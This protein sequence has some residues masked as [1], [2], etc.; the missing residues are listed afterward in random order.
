MALIP[1]LAEQILEEMD[2]ESLTNEL[3]SLSRTSRFYARHS[4]SQSGS[5]VGSASDAYSDAGSV[6]VSSYSGFDGD[7]SSINMEASTSSWVDRFSTSSSHRE[8]HDFLT[9]AGSQ[10]SDSIT[11]ASSSLSYN[12]V[13]SSHVSISNLERTNSNLH[14]KK[15]PLPTLSA[16]A[17]ENSTRTKSQLWKE[18]KML[19]M[20]SNSVSLASFT[21][22]ISALTRTLTTLYTTTLLSLLTSIQ[23][24]LLARERYLASVLSAER[25]ERIREAAPTLSGLI[26]REAVSRV[27]DI[28][29]LWPSWCADQEDWDE[30]I[31]GISDETEMRFLTLSW[32]ILHVGWK[33]VAARVRGSVEAA[34]EGYVFSFW[35]H[36]F[37][38]IFLSEYPSRRNCHL[39]NF[40]L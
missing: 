5:E 16:S 29:A 17:R 36:V 14:A 39:L 4:A 11:T 15:E 13:A 35:W 26:L 38:D 18:V 8:P 24:A 27:I 34:F 12:P 37:T 30:E 22:S 28:E 19:S 7:T 31:E 2:V 9:S 33:D 21:Q 6:S 3:Q 20:S 1:T 25:A 32:W 23:L 10:L 40:M